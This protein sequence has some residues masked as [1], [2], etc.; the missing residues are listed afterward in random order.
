MGA[1]EA[2]TV[3]PEMDAWLRETRR[4]LHRHPELSLQETQTVHIVAGHLRELGI[5]HR[6]SV[7]GDG[8]SLFMSAETSQAAG[9]TPS[10]TTG[11]T[12]VVDLIHGRRPGRT[13]LIRA[14]MDVL[15]I[16]E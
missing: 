8:R 2:I 6:T 3:S 10:P 11:G 7:S 15:P 12:A 14:D 9:I 1:I 5:A 16:T 13:L 4:Y